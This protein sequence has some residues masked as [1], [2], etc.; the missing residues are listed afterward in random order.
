M[1]KLVP[2]AAAFLL[3]AAIPAMAYVQPGSLNQKTTVGSAPS[4]SHR[5]SQNVDGGSGP[6]SSTVG[7]ERA[8]GGSVTADP[9]GDAPLENGDTPTKP[10]PEPGTMA[11]ASMGLIAIGAAL[12]H[13]RGR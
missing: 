11:M 4:K 13:K 9:F 3:L 10:V 5:T 2:A 1:K 12:R 6:G 8:S 7:S